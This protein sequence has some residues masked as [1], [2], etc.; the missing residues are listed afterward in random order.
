MRSGLLLVA[1]C[2][3]ALLGF[4][5]LWLDEGAA[6]L[7]PSTLPELSP[8]SSESPEPDLL[9]LAGERGA[10]SATRLTPTRPQIQ[11]EPPRVDERGL[12]RWQVTGRLVDHAGSALADALIIFVPSASGRRALGMGG[13]AG[14]STGDANRP[15][16]WSRF[17]A[18]RSRDDGS[19]AIVSRDL[20]PVSR[21]E[22][23]SWSDGKPL[24]PGRPML[25]VEHPSTRT[26]VIAVIEERSSLVTLGELRLEQ[27]QTW[28]GRAVDEEGQ[29]IPDVL[30]RP[31]VFAQKNGIG[32]FEAGRV[33]LRQRL[34][35]RTD[36][37]GR[38]ALKAMGIGSTDVEL[39]ADGWVQS[40][41]LVKSQQAGD[42]DLGD[43]LL[44]PGGVLSGRVVDGTGQPRA[45]LGVLA[46]PRDESVEF[47]SDRDTVLVEWRQQEESD[48]RVETDDDGA[49]LFDSL[50]PVEFD[51][52]AG[53]PGLEPAVLRGTTT[54]DDAPTL[55]V[56]DEARLAL[57][58]VDAVTGE[59]VAKARARAHRLIV[60]P[61]ERPG[62]SI[63]LEP[64]LKVRTGRA[65]AELAGRADS[66]EGF[67]LVRTA[68]WAGS[69]LTV[70]APGYADHFMTAPG[71]SAPEQS[72]L[73]VSLWPVATL[74][75]RVLD[76]QG[77]PLEGAVLKVVRELVE[78]H[79]RRQ[80]KARSDSAG[81]FLFDDLTQGTWRLTASVIGQT[82]FDP[83]TIELDHAQALDLGALVM[84]EGG[85]LSGVVLDSMGEP[86]SGVGVQ[87]RRE[88]PPGA[89][90]PRMNALTDEW[91]R[92]TLVDVFPGSY[93]L[94]TVEQIQGQATVS[95]GQR[96]E[97]TLQARHLP[98]VFGRVMREGVAVE[99]AEVR[100][101]V[102]YDDETTVQTDVHGEFELTLPVGPSVLVAWDGDSS[103]GP[104]EVDLIFEQEFLLDI[105]IIPGRPRVVIS[106]D[107]LFASEPGDSFNGSVVA[108]DSEGQETRVF[109]GRERSAHYA[110]ED[111]PLGP[112]RVELRTFINTEGGQGM[113]VVLA[114]ASVLVD[115]KREHS[116]DFKDVQL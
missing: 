35:T 99:G 92:F 16:P 45:G 67:V 85:V 19:F 8:E 107:V 52:F 31:L 44:V 2:V 3:A 62:G 43:I 97:V 53:G 106:G 105:E 34:K 104:I 100:P 109:L 26:E 17:T 25:M 91:G 69:E 65:A 51:L 73:S 103:S 6:V 110:F 14:D 115:G 7:E 57:S 74:A 64:R 116:I 39:S 108:V 90:D 30:V 29:G 15:L 75:G 22:W 96:T 98:R 5:W 77:R 114:S 38:F 33:A 101:H 93:R 111:L 76:E 94:R 47:D 37:E 78:V 71:V 84:P 83:L 61:G 48:H 42:R 24:Y 27:G 32:T 58:V 63:L 23:V 50:G 1:L 70:S 82:P 72:K 18:V 102:F 41:L 10:P 54:D 4:A 87:A 20:A 46:R 60:A 79:K 68:G 95:R 89:E 81:R 11:R 21:D 59:P 55:V 28:I 80:L 12:S 13:P 56:K 40:N 66:G 113:Q 9:A 88:I 86:I 112:Y 49:F 36:D